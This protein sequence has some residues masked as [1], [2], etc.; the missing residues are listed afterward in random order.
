M[1]KARKL[2]VTLLVLAFVLSTF[3]VGFAAEAEEK[4]PAEVVRA[5]ALGI[6][7]GDEKGNLNLDKPVTRAEALALIVR[8]SGLEASAEL[9]KGQTQFADVNTDPSL[10]WATGYINLGV[11]QGII[12][13]YPD[14]TFKG[15]GQVT[16]AEMAKMLL[17]A[18]NYGV[19]VE[20]GV[21]PAAV[22]GKADDLKL[23][24]DVNAV[25]NIPALRGDVVKMID[26]SLTVK[27]LVQKGYGDL[28]YYDEGT[29]TFLSKMK[30]KELED[31]RVTQIARVNDKL[32]DDEIELTIYD[33][34]GDAVDSDIYTLFADASP[35][36]IFGLTVDAWVNDDDEVIF[37]EI[38][39]ADK[40][41]LF[42]TV[43][44]LDAE[45]IT[46]KDA[47]KTYKW[48]DEVV[49][50]ANFSD[51]DEDLDDVG[52]NAYCKIVLD[53]GRVVF[54]A[55]FI[56]DEANVGV[57]T[58]VDEDV[59]EYVNANAD[60]TDINLDDYDHIYVYN[61]DLSRADVEDIVKDSAIFFWEGSDDDIYIIVKNES[62]EGEVDRV[63]ADK[64]RVEGT[65]YNRGDYAIFTVDDG[66]EYKTWLGN[67]E[68]IEDFIG[69]EVKVIFDLRGRVLLVTGD[70]ESKSEN[71]YG[72]VTYAKDGRNVEL[73]IFNQEGK[74]VEYKA[75]RKLSFED[76][77]GDDDIDFDATSFAVIKFKVNSD[78]EIEEND[79]TVVLQDGSDKI[80][81][82]TVLAG[83]FVKVS[84]SKTFTVDGGAKHYITK[85][86]V[87]MKAVDGDELDPELLSA[88][89]LISNGVNT[90]NNNVIVFV[91]E[92]T[93][94]AEFIVF[95]DAGFQ[96]LDEDLLY[97]VVIDSYWKEG[98]DYY[99]A[100][101][102]FGVGV[103]EY[104]LKDKD[105][106]ING[107]VV[108]FNLNTKDEAVFDS[109]VYATVYN[110]A[111]IEGYDKG[112]LEV[113]NKEVKVK[114]DSS[115]VIYVLKDN[116]KVDK[117]ISAS[118]LNDYVDRTITYVVDEEDGVIVAATISAE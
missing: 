76:I 5:Q 103:K 19:T 47:D 90:P 43:K 60:K 30:V 29:D 24:E 13:G 7:R 27:H 52:E 83:A 32:E 50:Y 21:W 49:E 37:V 85:D 8:I 28:A 116:G 54:A 14:G 89:K 48:A 113:D 42:D 12:N 46:L 23:F 115:A 59:I 41:I 73:T 117:K 86:T 26:N 67:E 68:D 3:N 99:N 114:V 72:I 57:V 20:G 77:F 2:L 1:K 78:G 18:M 45:G 62:V 98:S 16:Y 66:D 36:E 34:D 93:R 53:R 95:T 38:K 6:L 97:G 88:E 11:G 56:F 100:I 33:K 105:D 91:K 109:A 74:E 55:Y 4:L 39:T 102:V 17:Y 107:D 79:Y 84:D 75:E 25:P 94:D 22:M 80:G 104:K 101:N 35:E 40:D 44:E 15:N 58:D 106:F 92:N 51:N 69:E 64:I 31:V 111:V 110:E 10:Q 87:V 9:M 61:P 108:V 70:A 82:A 81:A 96:A 65:E 118:R 71:L 63:R 112:Y